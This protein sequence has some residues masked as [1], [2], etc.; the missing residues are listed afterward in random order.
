MASALET[1]FFPTLYDPGAYVPIGYFPLGVPRVPSELLYDLDVD[2]A[3]LFEAET[4]D[5]LL[6]TATAPGGSVPCTWKLLTDPAIVIDKLRLSADGSYVNTATVTGQLYDGDGE[7]VG[8][9]IAFVYETSSDGKYTGVLPA[10]A[11]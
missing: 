2:T 5:V 11:D 3:L 10:D 4:Q 1:K 6:F 7:A 8:S 9:E